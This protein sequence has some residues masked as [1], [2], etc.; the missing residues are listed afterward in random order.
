VCVRASDSKGVLFTIYAEQSAS[1]LSLHR[2]NLACDPSSG[3]MGVLHY[4]ED[5]DQ[6]ILYAQCHCRKQTFQL[7][8]AK[9]HFPLR[10]E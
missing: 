7:K 4:D 1:L 2:H 10:A 9:Q 8:V 6:V 5:K 3:E